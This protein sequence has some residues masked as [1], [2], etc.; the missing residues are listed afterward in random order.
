METRPV[1]ELP[2]TLRGIFRARGEGEERMTR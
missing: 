2:D 1:E